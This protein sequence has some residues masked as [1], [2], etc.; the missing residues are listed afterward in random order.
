VTVAVSVRVRLPLRTAIRTRH[1][2]G[3]SVDPIR[4]VTDSDPPGEIGC[5]NVIGNGPARR[6]LGPSASVTSPVAVSGLPPVL[7][8]TATISASP[9]ERSA[10]RPESVNIGAAAPPLATVR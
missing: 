1:G 7:W 2:P 8:T 5:R 3:G 4:A 9:P 6:P 10:R